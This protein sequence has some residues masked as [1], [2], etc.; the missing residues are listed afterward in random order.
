ME[1][2]DEFCCIRL[3]PLILLKTLGNSAKIRDFPYLDKNAEI[4]SPCF[5][6][7][8]ENP[9]CS[10]TSVIISITCSSAVI[11]LSGHAGRFR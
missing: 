6:L 1:K 10:A 5:T 2:V 8:S 3:T 11:I 9:N 7:I 4:A